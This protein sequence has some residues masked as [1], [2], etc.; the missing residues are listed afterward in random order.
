MSAKVSS[1]I[2]IFTTTG[3]R[4]I[5]PLFV[6]VGIGLFISPLVLIFARELRTETLSHSQL[7][8]PTPLYAVLGPEAPPILRV[9]IGESRIVVVRPGMLD[10]VLREPHIQAL[11]LP[12]DWADENDLKIAQTDGVRIVT[13][14]RHTTVKAI[15][16]NIRILATLTDTQQIGEHWIRTIDD[17][18][19]RIQHDVQ[20]FNLRRVL[21]LTPEGYTQGQGT[22][23]TDLLR[24][25]G[26]INVAAEAGIP[27]A[28]QIDDSQ[29]RQ[30]APDVVLLIGWTPQTAAILTQNPLYKGILAFDR[31]RVYLIAPP[32]KD[33][34]NLIS[35]TNRLTALI[36]PLTF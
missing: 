20:P 25:A 15:E 14:Q 1:A 4:I 36:H 2:S 29:I 16:A 9:L 28:R 34:A 5:V 11:I 22:L 26:G 8:D 10:A 31:D 13:L 35:D 33:P 3:A 23:M 17:G 27:E 12:Q 7:T 32:G 18:L 6:F 30:F 21:I 19:L 24:Y